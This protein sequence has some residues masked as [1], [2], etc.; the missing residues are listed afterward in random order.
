[1]RYFTR[2]W[3]E[4]ELTDAECE[5]ANAAYWARIAEIMPRLPPDLVRLVR[6]IRLHDG[7]IELVS[8]TAH[9]N[10]LQLTLVGENTCEECV[11]VQLTYGGAM[12]SRDRLASLKRAA[13]NRETEL[14]YD[15]VDLAD[16]ILSHRLLFT[17]SEEVTI[18]FRAFEMQVSSRTDRRVHLRPAFTED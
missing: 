13:L 15:E 9:L 16:G 12:L 6:E 5:H 2:G 14:L 4:G 11:A 8:W 3:V 10:R 18:D 7:I 1:M 17:P